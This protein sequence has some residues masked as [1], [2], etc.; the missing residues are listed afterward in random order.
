[1]PVL[2]SGQMEEVEETE[3]QVEGAKKVVQFVGVV[4]EQEAKE[5]KVSKVEAEDEVE[6]V[7]VELEVLE[8]QDHPSHYLPPDHAAVVHQPHCS[9]VKLNLLVL[10]EHQPHREGAQIH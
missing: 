5:V 3:A 8:V 2:A 6:V 10:L 4:E 1:M 7:Q 9:E